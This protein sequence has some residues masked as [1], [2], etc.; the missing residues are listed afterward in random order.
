[1]SASIYFFNYVV[2]AKFHFSRSPRS[3][4]DVIYFLKNAGDR[5]KC[6]IPILKKMR[7]NKKKTCLQIAVELQKIKNAN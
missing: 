7:E 2:F 3:L 5:S 6:K 1:M 4:L